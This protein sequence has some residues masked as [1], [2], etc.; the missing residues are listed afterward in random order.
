M[1]IRLK[2]SDK[3]LI[4]PLFHVGGINILF[5]PALLKSA[6]VVLQEKFE[7]DQALEII[8]KFKINKMITVPTILDQM[9]KSRF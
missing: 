3:V 8:R 6:T 4:F 1:H 9:I 7:P 5:L 2:S